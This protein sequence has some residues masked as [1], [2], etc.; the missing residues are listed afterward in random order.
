M[1][2]RQTPSQQVAV[3]LDVGGTNIKAGVITRDGQLDSPKYFSDPCYLNSRVCVSKDTFH[4]SDA[5]H[6]NQPVVRKP[7]RDWDIHRSVYHSRRDRYR[8]GPPIS[9]V[10][11]FQLAGQ[12]IPGISC[13]LL[14]FLDTPAPTLGEAYYGAGQNIP[15]LAY[16]T[17]STGIGAGILVN[18]QYFTGGMGWAGGIG[19]IIID[20]SSPRQCEACGNYGCLETFAAKRGI[21]LTAQ[22]LLKIHPE[23]ILNTLIDADLERITPQLIYEAAK[24]GDP[25]AIQV[26][27]RAGHALGF[28]LVSMADIV[29]PTRIIVGGGIACAGDFLLQPARDVVRARA[30]PPQ[31]RQVEIVQAA[32]GDLSGIFGA[33]AMVFHRLRINV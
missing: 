15:D 4:H 28:G 10:G 2:S 27:Q 3:A 33:A 29:S 24:A 13:G 9:R 20:E 5:V 1:A 16:V 31:I 19:H 6:S 11:G 17:V 25:T 8:H 22:D 32:L 21:I 14:L 18:G 12:V 26:F 23:S 7:E 30:F